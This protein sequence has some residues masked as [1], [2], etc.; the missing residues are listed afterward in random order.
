MDFQ[1]NEPPLKDGDT[2]PTQTVPAVNTGGDGRRMLLL[3]GG[4]AAFGL[5]LTLLA[6]V[7]LSGNGGDDDTSEERPEVMEVTREAPPTS[8]PAVDPVEPTAPTTDADAASVPEPTIGPPTETVSDNTGT[9]SEFSFEAAQ[10]LL[11]QP[12]TQT[13]AEADPVGS[14]LRIDGANLN[15]FTIIPDRPRDTLEQYT[16]VQGDT[17]DG[18]AN[19]FG[20]ESET[21]AWSNPRRIIQVMRPGDVLIVPPE[22]GVFV[23]AQ[24]I[25]RTLSDYAEQYKVEVQAV[26]NHPVNRDIANLPPNQVPPSGTPI[27]FP[28]GEAELIVWRAEIEVSG[29]S[30]GDGGGGGVPTVRFQPGQPGDCGA[31]PISGGTAWQNP[32]PSGYTITRGYSPAHP[33][34]DLAAPPGTAI[35]AANGGVV[36]FSGWNSY[37]YGNMVAIIHG[38]NMT[39]YGHMLETPSVGCGQWVD[40][41]SIIGLVGSTGNSSG[42]HL[43]FEIRSGPSYTAGNPA[44]TIGF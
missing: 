1:N 27:F 9:T 22:D 20:L 29:G 8:P 4:L 28:G 6:I 14:A 16:V 31:V 34:I 21:I 12:L 38:P 25:E 32:M 13:I 44:A 10:N 36:I 23:Y 43:H 26:L 2:R 3:V 35:T 18:I 42:P 11:D 37:G 7:A 15:P 33:G 39:V 24:G 19:R 40:A 17:I 5:V 41:G 30:G